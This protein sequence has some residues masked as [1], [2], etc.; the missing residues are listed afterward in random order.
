MA[1][2]C[3]VRSR[4]E[5]YTRVIRACDY[6]PRRHGEIRSSRAKQQVQLVLCRTLLGFRLKLGNAIVRQEVWCTIQSG[7][8][9]RANCQSTSA[10]WVGLVGLTWSGGSRGRPWG[11][12]PWRVGIVSEDGS[13]GFLRLQ[14]HTGNKDI[15]YEVDFQQRRTVVVVETEAGILAPTGFGLGERCLQLRYSCQLESVGGW[16]S[17]KWALPE[18][19][20]GSPHVAGDVL[21][22]CMHCAHRQP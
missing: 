3:R 14:F 10:D 18:A 12:N 4:G 16:L 8:G 17:H 13:H 1:R 21:C 22:R 9:L 6:I 20:R 2:R 5:G 11:R 15:R 7:T 19:P